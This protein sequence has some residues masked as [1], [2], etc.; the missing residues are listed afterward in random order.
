ML[1]K[2]KKKMNYFHTFTVFIIF[3]FAAPGVLQ[4][5]KTGPAALFPCRKPL[6]QACIHPVFIQPERHF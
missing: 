3:L 5:K 2:I 6:L 4:K 1:T